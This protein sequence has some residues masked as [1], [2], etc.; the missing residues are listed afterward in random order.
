MS[1]DTG[2]GSLFVDLLFELFIF[3]GY[4][5]E[6]YLKIWDLWSHGLKDIILNFNM[7]ALFLLLFHMS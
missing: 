2:F 7:M 3:D 6:W 1:I 5:R 4:F